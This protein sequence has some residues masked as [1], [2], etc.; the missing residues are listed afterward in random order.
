MTDGEARGQTREFQACW[1]RDFA[2]SPT[3][4]LLV[5]GFANGLF[6]DQSLVRPGQYVAF[7]CFSTYPYSRGRIHVERPDDLHSG[8]AFDTGFLEHKFD[9]DV[10]VW[11]YKKQREIARRL[12]FCTGEVELG[13]PIFA[14]SSNARLGPLDYASPAL[15]HINYSASDDLI[16]EDWVRG[17]AGTIWH[18]L[19]TCAMKPLGKDGVVDANLNVHGTMGLKI[20]DLSVVPENVGANTNNTALV[21]GEKAAIIIAAELAI[22]F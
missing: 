10:M 19:G 20:A 13:H 22:N 3:K 15:A 17:N 1:E 12:P 4:P 2:P 18:S 9:L 21:I 8:Y 16:I 6:G 5:C 14:E 11:A 7:T